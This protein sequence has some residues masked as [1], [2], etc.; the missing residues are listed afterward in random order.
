MGENWC[1]HPGVYKFGEEAELQD[2][3][4]EK[5]CEKRQISIDISVKKSPRFLEIFQIFLNFW[6]KPAEFRRKSSSF[7]RPDG[8]HSANIG[9]L[10]FFDKVQ[11]IFFNSFK[12][13]H[14][15]SNN[16]SLSKPFSDILDKFLKEIIEFSEISL[17]L[18]DPQKN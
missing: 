16:P 18:Q 3:Y 12:D 11:P 17:D 9:D 15:I 14:P 7:Y 4:L 2:I 5:I 6:S 13:F 10:S 1:Y 8:N